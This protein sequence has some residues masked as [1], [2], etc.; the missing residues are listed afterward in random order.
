[1]RTTAS[2]LIALAMVVFALGSACSKKKEQAKEMMP[3]KDYM[4]MGEY[5]NE[6]DSLP[7]LRYFEGQQVSV[8]N[9]CAVRHTK[10]NP[11]MPPIYVNGQPVGFC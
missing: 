1:M 5:V 6:Q 10:L 11:K 4:V 3:A 9:S 7:H 8:N 2:R